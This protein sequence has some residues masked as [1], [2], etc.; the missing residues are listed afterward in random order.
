MSIRQ[1]AQRFHESGIFVNSVEYP[2]VP[3]NEQRFRVSIMATHTEED[4]DR[5]LECTAEVWSDLGRG[6]ACASLAGAAGM[7]VR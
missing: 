5:L 6:E 3:L 2:A 7:S 4:I 1:A